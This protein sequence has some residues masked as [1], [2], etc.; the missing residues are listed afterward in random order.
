ML[1]GLLRVQAMHGYQLN[2]F[3][4]EHMDFM[5]SIKPST[6]Y[7]GLERLAEEGLVITREEQAGNRPTRQIYEI[8]PAG[9]AEFQRLLRENLRRY[10]PG[11]SAD[12][13]GIA[14]LSALPA[15][16]VYPWLAEKRAAIQA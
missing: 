2:Q 7:Y 16:E 9:E 14:F 8:T 3:L 10:D 11:E 12:D 13:I 4:E 1:L 6:V 5:P 15:G